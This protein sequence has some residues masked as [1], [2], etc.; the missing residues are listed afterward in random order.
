[1]YLS[2]KQFYQQ[3]LSTLP[4]EQ[5]YPSFVV[6]EKLVAI[7]GTQKLKK[8]LPTIQKIS[9][10]TASIIQTLI[11]AKKFTKK[12]IKILT[13]M[14]RKQLDDNGIYFRVTS[15]DV[16][17]EKII[18]SSLEKEYTSPIIEYVTSPKIGIKIEGEGLAYQRNLEQDLQNIFKNLSLSLQTKND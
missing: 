5:I 1:M 2:T 3:Y 6:L 17:T 13:T 14:M 15:P 10:E 9:L 4:I 12:E 11:T 18:T 16:I 8:I 7:Q